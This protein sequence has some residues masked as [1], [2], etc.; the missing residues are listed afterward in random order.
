MAHI[1]RKSKF[2]MICRLRQIRQALG[3]TQAELAR[4]TGLL[5]G[6]ISLIENRPRATH[7]KTAIKIAAALGLPFNEIWVM[8]EINEAP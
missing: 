4:A 3:V 6:S 1:S 8:T 2:R 7:P 5:E